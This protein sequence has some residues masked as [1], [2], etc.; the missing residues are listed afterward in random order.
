[1]AKFEVLHDALTH[2]GRAYV[3]GETVDLDK[4]LGDRLASEFGAVRAAAEKTARG[5]AKADEPTHEG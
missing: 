1:M 4:D 5:R 2:E 3:R